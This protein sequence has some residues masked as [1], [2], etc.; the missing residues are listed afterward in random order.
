MLDSVANDQARRNDTARK[1][2]FNITVFSSKNVR[3]RP[4]KTITSSREYSHRNLDSD[5]MWSQLIVDVI[6]KMKQRLRE[7]YFNIFIANCRKHYS[8]NENDLNTGDELEEYYHPPAALF[9]Y[10]RDSFLYRILNRALRCRDDHTLIT[11]SFF[12]R[13]I[14]DGLKRQQKKLANESK[15]IRVYRGQSMSTV[16]LDRIKSNVGKFVSMNSFFSTTRNRQMASEIYA[17][18]NQRKLNDIEAGVLF[19]IDAD[20]S[21]VSAKPFA[22]ITER[23]AFDKE[24]Q[25]ILFM[26]G[27]IFKVIDVSR[28]D[29]T[30]TWIIQLELSNEEE[31]SIKPVFEF[32]KSQTPEETDLMCIGNIYYHMGKYFE[33][34]KYFQKMS[35]SLPEN[36]I[37]LAGCYSNLGMIAY[38]GYG[39]Y[40]KAFTHYSKALEFELK[41]P[42]RHKYTLGNIFNNLGNVLKQ[43]GQYAEALSQFDHVFNIDLDSEGPHGIVLAAAHLNR[44]LVYRELN[45]FTSALQCMRDSLAIASNELPENHPTL[46]STYNYIA[47]VQQSARNY[48]ESIIYFQKALSIQLTIMPDHPETAITYNNIG[49][50]HVLASKNYAEALVNYEKALKIYENATFTS[51]HPGMISL[52]TNIG[53]L[54]R[55]AKNHELAMDYYKRALQFQLEW[56][57]NSPIIATIYN[58]I[59][60]IYEEGFE[61]YAE[62]LLN[63]KRAIEMFRITLSIDHP[64]LGKTLA[65]MADLYNRMEDYELALTNYQE[66]LKILSVSAPDRP[67]TAETH[68]GLSIT[69]VNGFHNYIDALVNLEIGLRIYENLSLSDEIDTIRQCIRDVQQLQANE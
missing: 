20:T 15:I 4:S 31:N 2:N 67:E 61:N 24:E 51:N 1:E 36:D 37:N 52:L 19:E 38:Y 18:A 62:A 40:D 42:L 30:N 56:T 13:D 55:C 35:S 63:Y 60:W 28:H 3:S 64:D 47:L 65:R 46:A 53:F 11:L 10:T 41:K 6:L 66:A 5:F 9:W 27:S 22:D 34:E 21:L 26:L 43:Q 32:L 49:Q 58:N 57:E 17:G 69:Y 45:D 44:G 33:A 16:E 7:D 23:S 54:H 39:D 50:T 25:E 12:I 14:H 48:E 29:E 59:G 68:A 8:G